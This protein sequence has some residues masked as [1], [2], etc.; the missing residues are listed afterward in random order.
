MR[1]AL[2]QRLA[3]LSSICSLVSNAISRLPVEGPIDVRSDR[4]SERPS[5]RTV[6]GPAR[7]SSQ[8]PAAD[9]AKCG[10]HRRAPVDDG[11]FSHS[12]RTRVSALRGPRPRLLA[13]GNDAL[14]SAAF[15]AFIS[16]A[17]GQAREAA[18]SE[19]EFAAR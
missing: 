19:S 13:R 4:G 5:R 10:G 15:L 11:Q 17:I 16:N 1:Y 7:L 9:G 14:A 18:S 8:V 3:S 6:R 2:R 12:I